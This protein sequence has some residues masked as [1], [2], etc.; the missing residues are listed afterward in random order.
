M[1]NK[2]RPTLYND[3]T[4]EQTLWYIE[5]YHTLDQV[6]PSIEGLA[7]HLKVGV[8]TIQDWANDETKQGF[9]R[10]LEDLKAKQATVTLNKGLDGTFNSA[11]TKLLLHN[12]GYTD[13]VQHSGD[14]DAPLTITINKV[15]H[16][17]RDND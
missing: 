2:G 4:I 12:H 6:V 14:D 8:R 15:L 7:V 13:K 1:A 9:S 10:T 17:A 11:I 5:N 3:S 16:S